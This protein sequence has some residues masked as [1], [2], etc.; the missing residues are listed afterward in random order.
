MFYIFWLVS[1][2][3]RRNLYHIGHNTGQNVCFLLVCGYACNSKAYN[4][5]TV[6]FVAC[7]SIL[8][9]SMKLI[10]GE[11]EE[12]SFTENSQKQPSEVFCKKGVLANFA[13]FLRKFLRQSLFFNKVAG[14]WKRDSG[15]DVFLWILRNF[16]EHVFYRTPPSDCFSNIID[17]SKDV[18]EIFLTYH[19]NKTTTRPISFL[20]FRDFH[21]RRLSHIF[22]YLVLQMKNLVF[23]SKY[24][25]FCSKT[26]F[27]NRF[28]TPW[29]WKTRYFEGN[30]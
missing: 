2:N 12:I 16:E 15:T 17:L 25:V 19:T 22:D 1:L 13:K 26:K 9:N 11:T 8:R 10:S 27:W 29:I 6:A 4:V 18:R 23:Q 24:L 3:K 7:S 21:G 5:Y 28:F 30:T 14:Y 20:W